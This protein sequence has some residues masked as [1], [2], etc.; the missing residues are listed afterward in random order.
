ME[1][2]PDSGALKFRLGSAVVFKGRFHGLSSYDGQ[3]K[4]G[5]PSSDVGCPTLVSA[6]ATYVVVG[7]DLLPPSFG[8]TAYAVIDLTGDAPE[9]S[10]LVSGQRPTDE[11]LPRATRAK[12]DKTGFS[13]SY[14]GYPSGDPGGDAGSAKP[15]QHVVRYDFESGKIRQVN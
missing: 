1:E 15:H 12:W 5:M 8:V 10:E 6:G 14:F 3:L 11:K 9:W 7:R 13:F 4:N 2:S